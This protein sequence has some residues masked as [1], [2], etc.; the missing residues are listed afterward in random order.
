MDDV[1][2]VMCP[3]CG[4]P[5]R[6]GARFCEQCGATLA[7][8]CPSCR[9]EVGASARFCAS[10]GH[11][12]DA[13]PAVV[14]AAA[15][16][17]VRSAATRPAEKSVRDRVVL[18]GERRTVTVVF[19]DAVG[20]T[21]LAEQLGE[22]E[23]YALMQRCLARMTE[24]VHRFDGHIAH[25]GGDGGMAIFGAPIAHEDSAR[26]AVAAGLEM[27]RALQD[28]SAE[29][30]DRH[31]VDC[32]FRV[33]LNTG[34]VVVGTISD[35]LTMDFTAVGDT[36][37][38]AARMQQL[39]DPG[40]V[41]VS[42][43]T[44]RAVRDFF[45]C[46]PLGA[47]VAKGKAEP[48]NAYR[49]VREKPTRTRLEVAT[50]RG[51][52]AFVGRSGELAALDTYLR[53]TREGQGQ[54]V[55]L[56]GEAGMGKSR[57][58][59]EFR[60]RLAEQPV[61]WLEGHCISYGKDISYLPMGEVVKRAF[62][63]EEGDGEARIIERVDEAT[64]GW[65]VTGQATVPYLKY[66]LAVDPGV[67][68]VLTMDPRERRAGILDALRT[69][70]VEQA[71]R[72]PLVVVVEDLHWVDEMTR[73]ALAA[74]VDVVPTVPVLLVLTYRPGYEHA[75]GERTY[76]SR[77]ALGHLTDEESA[78]LA[79]DV[80]HAAALPEELERLIARKAE[81]N[82]FYVEEETKCL[83]EMGV[84]VTANGSYTLVRPV[85]EIHI[86]NTIQ[87]VILSRIDRLEHQARQ[88][89]QLASV[90]G[91]E[92][93][94]RL[95][96]R[97][98]DFETKLD[99]ALSE[100]KA[101]ELIY[102]KL[103]SP[104]LAYMFKHALTHDVAYS[105]LLH[106]RR[107][108]LHR[109]VGAAIEELYADRL[110]EQ[111]EALAH[112]YY[113]AEEWEKALDYLAK[114][115]DKAAA[116]YANH[117]ALAFYGRG[118]E[119]CEKLGDDRLTTAVT[120]AHRRAL[121]NFG[122]GNF[123]GAVVDFERKRAVGAALGDRSLEG[124]ALAHRGMAEWFNHELATAEATLQASLAAADEGPDECRALASLLLAVVY[125]ALGRRAEA[126]PLLAVVEQHEARLD[127]VGRGLWSWIGARL[128]S[129][130]GRFDEALQRLERGRP[131]AEASMANLLFHQ[132]NEALALAGRG[133]YQAALARLDDTL[134]TC[135]RVGDV[136]V[137][138]RI[139]N[140]YGWVYAELQDHERALECN[141]KGLEA[142]RATG[143]PMA[144]V[145]IQTLL[146]L[147]ENLLA[148]GR[149]DE[150]EEYFRQV[151]E[152]VRRPLPH[153]LWIHWRYSERFVH[154][155]G[156]LRLA[157]GDPDEAL[158]LADECIELATR[159]GSMK[160]VAKGRRLRAEALIAQGRLDPA[161]QELDAALEKAKQVGNPPQLWKTFVALGDLRRA[162]GRTDDARQAY[163]DALAVIEGV[164]AGLTDESLRPT[165]LASDHVQGIREAAESK[166]KR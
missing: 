71:A 10:C 98:S 114:A 76:I 83:L 34:P 26:Q 64:A 78:A 139:L 101:L 119:A 99:D 128:E 49:I 55:L 30:K 142:V 20:S 160:V 132:W 156:E 54:V 102:E 97:I 58:L 7:R 91:R 135:E 31:G 18:E 121:V 146:N 161:D 131:A 85:E 103:V 56:S 149:L 165:F 155:F 35:D 74:L 12:L 126:E 28:C 3:D 162:Q 53:R 105:T 5:A 110:P 89:I 47:L 69:L 150:A 109:V 117:D 96:D 77:L 13:P 25:F 80:L 59:L 141:R 127:D 122:I 67:P 62:G 21:G 151:E 73:G 82:P 60:R 134:A 50:E 140:T 2:A 147:G 57:L 129:W 124:M 16:A 68:A 27:Q 51:L 17:D 45:E 37:N 43:H 108:A 130:A 113:E 92:F 148:L 24:T 1:P 118:L 143:T 4:R 14:A 90:I 8:R 39:A 72:Q 75:L 100:L 133:D 61:T 145:E 40:A 81:G 154:S 107:K 159:S 36:V 38:L 116:A 144:E 65:G 106:E 32:P 93:T 79:A 84:L 19:V 94:V 15:P 123:A 86:P 152:A 115:G 11:L 63:V 87:E 138:M 70:V 104:E 41:L 112:H 23:M 153:Q 42:E 166:L 66:L 22:E 46:E 158:R 163:R 125:V 137:R 136:I 48:V 157:R 29:V 164:A 44:Y 88:A 6:V 52:A 33:G 9:S 111:Y 95:L 120:L